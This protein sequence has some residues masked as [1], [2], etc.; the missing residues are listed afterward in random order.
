[1]RQIAGGLA[2]LSLACLIAALAREGSALTEHVTFYGDVIVNHTV[3]KHGTYKLEFDPASSRLFI[4]SGQRVAAAAPASLRVHAKKAE[5]NA[6]YTRATEMGEELQAVKYGGQREE[7][8]ILNP[9]SAQASPEPNSDVAFYEEFFYDDAA[10]APTA[11]GEAVASTSSDDCDVASMS[12]MSDA[13]DDYDA[14]PPVD[15]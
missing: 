4:K 10:T 2:A 15:D 9:I 8:V 14:E 3:V 5:G 12:A 7:V 1:M 6:V 13:R 11:S